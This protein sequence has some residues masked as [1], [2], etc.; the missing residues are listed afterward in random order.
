MKGQSVEKIKD[1]EVD[2]LL[3]AE[4]LKEINKL[5]KRKKI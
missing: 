2:S 4:L 3:L 1:S 5:E